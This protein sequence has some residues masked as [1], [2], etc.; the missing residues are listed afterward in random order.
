MHNCILVSWS[1]FKSFC[2]EITL[3]L[4]FSEVDAIFSA[5]FCFPRCIN[6]LLHSSL[7]PWLFQGRFIVAIW[8]RIF[9]LIH[10]IY[11]PFMGNQL[12]SGP[13]LLNNCPPWSYGTIY[14][15]IWLQ[16]KVHMSVC[17]QFWEQREARRAKSACG[18]WARWVGPTYTQLQGQLVWLEPQ[19]SGDVVKSVIL[20]EKPLG[21]GNMW[22]RPGQKSRGDFKGAMCV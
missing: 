7:H 15:H 16:M 21:Q 11:L 9:P 1:L 10:K 6:S 12:F 5:A 2:S 20:I 22:R 4:N 3:F 13:G 14:I 8:K 17:I 18:T 19:A